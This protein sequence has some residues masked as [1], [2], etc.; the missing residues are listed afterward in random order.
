MVY[1]D[2]LIIY[3]RTAED[4]ARHVVEV[5]KVLNKHNLRLQVDKV[6]IGTLTCEVLGNLVS[7]HGTSIALEKLVHRNDLPQVKWYN[8]S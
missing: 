1:I 6:I 3:S 5:L 2:D 8:S 4:H 7:E